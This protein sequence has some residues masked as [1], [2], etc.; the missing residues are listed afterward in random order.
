MIDEKKLVSEVRSAI[1]EILQDRLKTIVGKEVADAVRTTVDKMH[2]EKAV[3][4]YDR[5]LLS[6]DQKS[7]FAKVVHAAAFG[8]KSNEELI[9]ESDD[10]GGILIPPDVASAI[11]RVARTVGLAMSQAMP[12]PMKGDSLTVPAYVGSVLEGEFL[13]VNAAGSLTS[14]SFEH[15][16]LFVK[17]WQLAFALGN[18]LLDDASVQLGEW[19][20]SLAAE[21]LANMVDKQVFA[22]T[23]NPF[24]GILQHDDV[25]AVT[26]G[27]GK[28]TFEE[29]DVIGD[30]SLVMGSMEESLLDGSAFYYH[31][32]V[33]ANLRV[34]KDDA[35]QFLLGAGL[36]T[37]PA[38]SFLSADP[39]SLAGPRPV[40]YVLNAPVY[41]CRHL[42]ALSASAASTKFGV[43]GNLKCVAYGEKGN[44]TVEKFTSGTFGGKEIALADQQALVMKKRFGTAITLPEGLLTIQTHS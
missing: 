17:K 6:D 33:W 5:S 27:T 16:N 21:A 7:M 31:R 35:G 20:V 29:F 25:T 36:G 44:M 19:L 9:V 10:R 41:T 37:V 22:G 30:S 32:T 43:F 26:L 1:D 18:D 24:V 15:A 34:Q 28:D 38:Q 3:W 40:G 4:G 39:K 42:P 13:G 12:W 14:I 11:V 8:R 2:M 23:G